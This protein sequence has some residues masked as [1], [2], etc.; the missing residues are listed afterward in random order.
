MH[1]TRM[2]AKNPAVQAKRAVLDRRP[3]EKLNASVAE[4]TLSLDRES[5]DV[6]LESAGDMFSLRAACCSIHL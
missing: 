3:L 4:S 5:I 1:Q 2:K 6:V